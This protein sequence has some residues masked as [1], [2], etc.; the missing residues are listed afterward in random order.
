MPAKVAAQ[1]P[2]Q[3]GPTAT[4]RWDAG[5]W[6]ASGQDAGRGCNR[7]RLRERETEGERETEREREREREVLPNMLFSSPLT[8]ALFS[9]A[10]L[11]NLRR[12]D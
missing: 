7:E 10:R 11:D 6:R 9:Q 4:F 12:N 3:Q 8:L 1:R 2:W 5:W